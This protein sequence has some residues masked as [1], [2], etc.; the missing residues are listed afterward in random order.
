MVEHDTSYN[1]AHLRLVEEHDMGH[2]EL[3]E[4]EILSVARHTGNSVNSKETFQ[5]KVLLLSWFRLY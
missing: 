1:G 5:S 4:Q 3:M 2:N